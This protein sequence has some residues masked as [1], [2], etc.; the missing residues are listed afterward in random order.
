MKF[1]GVDTSTK[2]GSVALLCDGKITGEHTSKSGESFSRSLLEMIDNILAAKGV[3]LEEISGFGVAIGPGSFTGIRIGLATL[4]GISLA[5]DLPIY[6]VSTL[7]AMALAAGENGKILEPMIDARNGEVYYAKFRYED[8]TLVRLQ[9]DSVAPVMAAM[10]PDASESIVFG[11]GARQ[12]SETIRAGGGLYR[13]D[14]YNICVAVGVAKS[15]YSRM[16]MGERENISAL[17]PNYIRRGQAESVK[18]LN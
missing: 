6:G 9:D 17:K 4:L 14:M 10:G 7:E 1:V 5:K 2:H 15:A 13:Q 8:E 12:Y 3:V 16:A 18:P 11:S